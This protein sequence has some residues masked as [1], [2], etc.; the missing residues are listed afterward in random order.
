MGR[1]TTKKVEHAKPGRHSDGDG[2]MLLVKPTGGKSWILRVQMSGKRRDIGL[3]SVS[4]FDGK[5]TIG[6][7]IPLLDKRVLTLAEARL[8]AATL[9]HFAKAGRDPVAELRKDRS[10]VR[11]FA[12]AAAETHRKMKP[13]WSEKTAT[14]FIVSLEQHAIPM[15]G[16]MPINEID[17]KA[18]AN[19]LQPIWTDKPMIAR[20]VRQRIGKVLNYSQAQGWRE[21]GMPNAAVSE[22]LP[23]Q[24]APGNLE[25]LPYKEVPAFLS[26][27]GEQESI[28]RLALRFLILTAAR[29]GEVRGARW[30]Q[31]DFHERLWNRPKEL[32]KGRNSKP[33]VVTLNAPA[34][35]VLQSASLHRRSDSD[36]IFPSRSGKVL[37]DMALSGFMKGLN[38]TP[39]GFRSSF[40]DFA[41]ER[42]PEIP[43]PVA[44]AALAHKVPDKV[45]AAY[46]RTNFLELRRTLLGAWGD[47]CDGKSD[48]APVLS[49]V[50]TDEV[51][52][53][54][55]TRVPS[56]E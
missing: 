41:A 20:K 6:D 36:L 23:L 43:D 34:I 50:S 26:A 17:P 21:I 30:S 39:H 19:T 7:E 33:H 48:A 51:A 5:I 11:S 35:A 9:R 40:R 8:K 1:L 24:A 45:I 13:Q 49:E 18:I 2:L 14:A 52:P 15:L 42:Q 22:L 55:V 54:E 46:K 29:S 3:G 16:A 56:L 53:S 12:Q 44:E 27:L 47:Y 25:A 28:G 31:I 10:P 32:M 38:A 4:D 37:S